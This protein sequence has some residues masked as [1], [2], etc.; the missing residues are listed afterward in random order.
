MGF[1]FCNSLYYC[2]R[3]LGIYQEYYC[4]LDESTY[5]C[6]LDESTYQKR[7]PSEELEI[8]TLIL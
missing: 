5:Y 7:K 1:F 6:Y 4:Y 3:F 8:E 2:K